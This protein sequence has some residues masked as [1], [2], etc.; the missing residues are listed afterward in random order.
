MSTYLACYATE[1][2]DYEKRLTPEPK[3]P[4]RTA[5]QRDRDRIIHSRAFRRLSHKTQ[6]LPSAE[7]DHYRTRL[8][9]SIEVSQIA[10]TLAR[11]LKVNE[12][13]A[14]TIALAHDLGHPPFAH[15]GEDVLQKLTSSYGGFDHN[16]QALHIVTS[17]EK[18]YYEYDGLNLCWATLEGLVKHNGP[19]LGKHARA[20]HTKPGQEPGQEPAQKL[21]TIIAEFNDKFSDKF[22]LQ[23][24]NFAGIEAQCAAIADDIAYDAHDID[25][26]LR[27]GFITLKGLS[28][29]ALPRQI[30]ADIEAKY[31]NLAID[32]PKLC[33]R[34]FV[35]KQIA[36]MLT[37]AFEETKRR[38][39]IL[40]PKSVK[41][42]Y[43]ANEQQVS[44]SSETFTKEK[45][46]KLFL[47][48]HFYQA[49]AL[50]EKRKKVE[51][52]ITRLFNYYINNNSNIALLPK[53]SRTPHEQEPVRK[54][55]NYIACMTDIFAEKAYEQLAAEGKL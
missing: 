40:K 20:P 26:G 37:D 47:K 53:E 6:V 39:A 17:L 4:L 13:L 28:E 46:L 31:P 49:P 33:G 23:L 43:E 21:P 50:L 12:D 54:A 44:F 32:N 19:L 7:G 42:V 51:T 1:G 36:A 38:L 27:S 11:L 29:L 41:D 34:M 10:R 55:V 25:D 15:A 2:E 18:Q 3:E 48:E 16:A 9:H 35:R 5:F 8:I 52:I 14:E 22:D 45:E 30:L 24:H